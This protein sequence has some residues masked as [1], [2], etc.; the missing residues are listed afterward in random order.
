MFKLLHGKDSFSG[1][2]MEK[3]DVIKM[4]PQP[5]IFGNMDNIH[6]AI[7]A[8]CEIMDSLKLDAKLMGIRSNLTVYSL[9]S[10]EEIYNT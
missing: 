9:S 7:M 10:I 8:H 5:Y 4:I 1:D 3:R 6:E 2:V